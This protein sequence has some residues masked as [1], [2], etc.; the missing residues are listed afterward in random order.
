MDA[1]LYLWKGR[2]ALGK[3]V[4]E[5]VGKILAREAYKDMVRN[6]NFVAIFLSTQ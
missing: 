1:Y 6:A 4:G 3:N 5:N 2:E